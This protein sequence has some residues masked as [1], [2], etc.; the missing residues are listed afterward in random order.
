MSRPLANL[1]LPAPGHVRQDR[2][3]PVGAHSEKLEI[4]QSV[5]EFDISQA[6]E[7]FHHDCQTRQ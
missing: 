1:K 7:A 6:I 2:H 4:G 3:V 5:V